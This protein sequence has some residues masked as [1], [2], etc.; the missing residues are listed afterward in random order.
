MR[1]QRI[2]MIIV[3]VKKC[4][5]VQEAIKLKGHLN[6]EMLMQ[7]AIQLPGRVNCR[8]HQWMLDLF[9]NF[10]KCPL[11]PTVSHRLLQVLAVTQHSCSG[12]SGCQNS[13]SLG[14]NQLFISLVVKISPLC[15]P[16]EIS[17]VPRQF[18][19]SHQSCPAQKKF[20]SHTSPSLEALSASH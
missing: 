8:K 13:S 3:K 12:C 1:C 15:N 17:S 9:H 11:L 14:R 18:C 5:W 6:K 2:I 10:P 20:V 19:L 16:C 4:N 7:S